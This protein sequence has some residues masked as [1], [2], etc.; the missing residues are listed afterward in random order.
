[1][2]S[3]KKLTPLPA[4]RGRRSGRA[5]RQIPGLKR[6]EPRRRRGERSEAVNSW[7]VGGWQLAVKDGQRCP[8][9]VL[10]FG[11]WLPVI[12]LLAVG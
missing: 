5:E 8:V 1:M 4:K 3:S 2:A 10:A 9:G 12:R 7:R 6:S 11:R